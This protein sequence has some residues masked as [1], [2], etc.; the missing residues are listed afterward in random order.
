MLVLNNPLKQ[1]FFIPISYWSIIDGF[2][3]SLLMVTPAFGENE[4][5]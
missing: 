1:S 3:V 4:L 5:E 2:S